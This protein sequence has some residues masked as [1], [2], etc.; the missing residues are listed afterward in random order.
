MLT[1]WQCCVLISQQG[2]VP[3]GR[4]V[5]VILTGTFWDNLR[6][7]LCSLSSPPRGFVFISEIAA[8][9]GPWLCG[10]CVLTPLPQLRLCLHVSGLLSLRW[11]PF[12][13]ANLLPQGSQGVSSVTDR[14][15]WASLPPHSACVL[16]CLYLWAKRKKKGK[17]LLLSPA[18]LHVCL[19]IIKRNFVFSLRSLYIAPYP[20]LA[21]APQER[22]E[23]VCT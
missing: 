12:G 11:K 20:K 9:Q 8:L 17:G 1:V 15:S 22:G 6:Q 23:C 19:L 4:P 14:K 13:T 7:L 5:T 16:C 3:E 10:A 2:A 18:A 21:P